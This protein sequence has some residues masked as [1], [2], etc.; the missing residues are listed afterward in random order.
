MNKEKSSRVAE[1]DSNNSEVGYGRPPK[2]HQFKKGKSGNPS[3][4]PRG[5]A[6][7]KSMDEVVV[8]ELMR[9][10][11]VTE[12]GRKKSISLI[13]LL[14]RKDLSALA[15]GTKPASNLILT[16]LRQALLNST[17]NTNDKDAAIQSILE[18]KTILNILP[19]TPIPK[20]PIL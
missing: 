3:G 2:Q 19:G 20:N 16:F 8:E 17:K 4:R 13:Q 14:I 15:K 9:P 12:N 5:R 11:T 18:S 10:V 1:T 7:R 6:P